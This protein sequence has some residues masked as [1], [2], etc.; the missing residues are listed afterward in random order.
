MWDDYLE[1]AAASIPNKY[2]A[3]RFKARVRAQLLMLYSEFVSQGRTQEAAA[4]EAMLRLG[5]PEAVALRLTAPERRQHGWLWTIS[6]VELMVGLAIMVISMHSE[7]FAG[8]ALG[9]VVSLWGMTATV[10]HSRHPGRLRQALASLREGARLRWFEG[11]G[12]VVLRV[13]VMGA[14][15]GFLAGLFSIL[16][17][18]LIDSNMMDPVVLSECSMLA[19]SVLMALGPWMVRRSWRDQFL[20][21]V[22]LQ[23]N[24]GLA[25]AMS[26]TGLL[27]WHP[28]LV[29]PPFFNWTLPLMVVVG[30][31]AY[32]VCIRLYRFLVA[33]REPIDAWSEPDELAEA[34]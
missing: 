28:G 34:I 15:S 8:M 11:S 18:N 7:Y 1:L 13:S 23:V 27:W 19:V 30:F 26:Y 10:I 9:R 20:R 31:A 33:V 17:W 5:A 12:R 22:Q 2:L 32:F 14:V 21:S 25:A 29:P 24:A 6:V 3:R 16:P 4:D